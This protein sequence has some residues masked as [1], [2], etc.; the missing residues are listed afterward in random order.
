MLI[1]AGLFQ[2]TSDSCSFW[3]SQAMSDQSSAPERSRT[4]SW[5]DPMIGA[6]LA[7][8]M[9]GLEYLQ[10]MVRGEVPP[11]PIAALLNMTIAE[12]S[13][14]RVVFQLEPAEYHYNP[15]GSVHGGVACTIFD[16]AMGCAVHSQL[17]AGVTY[18]TLEI[19]VNFL[20]PLTARTGQIS[21]V[22]T[23][24]YVG[25]RMATAEGQLVDSAGKLYGHATTTCMI[26]RP[27]QA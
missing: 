17:P 10:A 16:S 4:F 8:S 23:A 13:A 24:I 20:R 26:F 6:R 7:P 11:P 3:R 1:W 2:A 15:I 21:C 12:V 14:G 25:G 9:S 22:G 18:T 19:K 5:Q 27:D